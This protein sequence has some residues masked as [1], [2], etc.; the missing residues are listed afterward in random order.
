MG[1]VERRS[2]RLLDHKAAL[3]AATEAGIGLWVH[4]HIHQPFVHEPGLVIPFPVICAGSATQTNRWAH[5]EYVL[6]GS[7]LTMTRRV[8]NP[9]EGRFDEAATYQFSLR[10]A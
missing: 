5:N 6:D 1:R 9:E 4:G 10:T 3:A 7:E 2:H 8:W